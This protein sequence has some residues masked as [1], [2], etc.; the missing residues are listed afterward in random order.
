MFISKLKHTAFT[1]LIFVVKKA[2]LESAGLSNPAQNKKLYKSPIF[3]GSILR[4][5][6]DVKDIRC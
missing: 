3:S 2:G 6:E 1:R 4:R 5:T